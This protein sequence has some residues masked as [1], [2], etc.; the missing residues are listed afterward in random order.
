MSWHGFIRALVA[1]WGA[2]MLRPYQGMVAGRLLRV[3]E[4]WRRVVVL[5]GGFMQAKLV[6]EGY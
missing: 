6:V 4:V 5:G 3:G 2:A 1:K